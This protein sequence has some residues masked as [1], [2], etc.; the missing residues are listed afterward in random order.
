MA[1]E[2]TLMEFSRHLRE[3]SHIWV[4]FPSRLTDLSVSQNFCEVN[5]IAFAAAIWKRGKL[6][7]SDQVPQLRD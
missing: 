1:Q 2:R 5:G 7:E 3:F 6:Y 4:V